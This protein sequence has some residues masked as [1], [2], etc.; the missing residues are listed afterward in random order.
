MAEYA[1]RPGIPITNMP[2]PIGN[3]NRI[4][5]MVNQL[6]KQSVYVIFSRSAIMRDGNLAPMLK[7]C[8]L[9]PLSIKTR[10]QGI[11]GIVV[12]C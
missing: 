9:W 1:L 6:Q 10:I 11:C 12:C 5:G 8:R 4:T 7:K 2:L 3:K